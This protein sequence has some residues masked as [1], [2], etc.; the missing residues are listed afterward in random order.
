MLWLLEAQTSTAC[1]SSVMVLLIIAI[2]G[3]TIIAAPLVPGHEVLDESVLGEV[4]PIS[5]VEVAPFVAVPT[6]RS[7]L[8]VAT[9]GVSS[10]RLAWA[11]L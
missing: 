7:R 1:A 4:V 9:R 8:P 6:G 2:V 10:G 3:P 5:G 11:P